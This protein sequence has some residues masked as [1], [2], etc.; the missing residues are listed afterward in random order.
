MNKMLMKIGWRQ[1]L[2]EEVSK[3]VVEVE[4]VA[5]VAAVV[6]AMEIVTVIDAT[7]LE[8]MSIS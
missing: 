6:V 3:A 8:V 2:G 7:A 1:N 4:A 5:A